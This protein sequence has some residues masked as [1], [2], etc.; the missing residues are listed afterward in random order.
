VRCAK[1]NPKIKSHAHKAHQ[2]FRLAH[3]LCS[4]IFLAEGTHAI[5]ISCGLT[6][7]RLFAFAHPSEMYSGDK[8]QFAPHK[9]LYAVWQ[10]SKHLAGYSQQDA[11]EFFIAMLDGLH[12][13]LGGKP[14]TTPPLLFACTPQIIL[15]VQS[16]RRAGFASAD[17]IVVCPVAWPNVCFSRW[18]Q[19]PSANA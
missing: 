18:T 12:T 13:H 9:L 19:G 4:F 7:C 15:A 14:G 8:A 10:H 1:H 5:P 3:C 6:L 16:Y 17:L 2:I 11:H